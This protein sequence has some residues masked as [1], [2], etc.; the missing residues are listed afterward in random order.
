VREDNRFLNAARA[1]PRRLYPHP[2]G[3]VMTRLVDRRE[4]VFPRSLV[5]PSRGG[6][7]EPA[8]DA[9]R[10]A[11][12]STRPAWFPEGSI[13]LARAGRPSTGLVRP[14]SRN[15]FDPP[16]P[17]CV[18]RCGGL[19]P[20]PPRPQC[21]W[22]LL[23]PGPFRPFPKKAEK[24]F[25]RE[26]E[27]E[28]EKNSPEKAE[29]RTLGAGRD[30]KEKPLHGPG[31]WLLFSPSAKAFCRLRGRLAPSVDRAPFDCGARL[32]LPQVH[33]I[34]LRPFGGGKGA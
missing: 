30:G 25:R 10:Q 22:V 20:W 5:A 13:P 29:R 14:S 2:G 9:R 27:K 17:S 26:A 6:K 1:V 28:T 33:F 4:T 8:R 12:S 11:C 23:R 31:L 19:P 18:L 15:R 16:S 32:K 34:S 7:L 24:P 3:A 21:R